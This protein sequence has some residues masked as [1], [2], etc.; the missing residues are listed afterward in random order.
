MQVSTDLQI[1][2]TNFPD[3]NFRNYLLSQ[4]YGSDAFLTTAEIAGITSINVS[5]KNISDLT[6]IGYFTALTDLYCNNNQ[7]QT[8]DVSSNTKLKI[9]D[10]SQNQL[11]TLNFSANTALINL[12]CYRNQLTALNVSA[13]T[14]LTDLYCNDNQL[15][16][17][18]FSSN[19]KLKILDCSRNQL[20]TL[21]VSANTALTNLKCYTNQLTA[22]DLTGL[23]LGTFDGSGQ[24]ATLTMTYNGA[25]GAF[26]GNIS[27]NNPTNLAAGISY[28]NGTL[29]STNYTITSTPFTVSTN[30]G[31]NTL[32]GTL[33]LNYPAM[34]KEPT[35]NAAIDYIN[36]T[37][38]GLSSGFF[39]I[40]NGNTVNITGDYPINAAWFNTTL[41]IIKTGNGTTT[42]DSDP[43][44]I[45]I[46]ARPDAPATLGHTFDGRIT[47]VTSAMEYSADG[48]TWTTCPDGEVAGLAA[49]TYQVRIKATAS[50]FHS[51]NAIITIDSGEGSEINPYIIRTPE[52][53]AM[54][55][56]L[57]NAD[58]SNYT[59]FTDK[60]YRLGN[61]IDLTAYLSS[62]GAGYNSGKGWIP[63]GTINPFKGVFDGGGFSI[64]G[65]TVNDNTLSN[66]GLFGVLDGATIKNLGVAGK[67]S[68]MTNNCGG[69]AGSIYNGS[70]IANCYSAANISGAGCV[71]GLVGYVFGGSIANCYSTGNVSGTN[72]EVG[73]I[74]G[75]IVNG[76]SIANCYAT[77]A[78]SSGM[79]QAGGIAGSTA[80]DCTI[81]NC[82]ALNPGVTVITNQVGRVVGSNSSTTLQNNIAFAG[83]TLTGF[84]IDGDNGADAFAIQI[85]TAT[86]LQNL[87]SANDPDN[88]WTY[89]DKYLPGLFG[90]TVD[91][92]AYLKVTG[93]EQAPAAPANFTATPDGNFAVRLDWTTPNNGGSAI[94]KYQ[95]SYNATAGYTPDWTD[96]PASDATTTS[97]TLTGLSFGTSYTFELRAVNA[98]G[99]GASSGVQTATPVTTDK[100]VMIPFQINVLKEGVA[101]YITC[102]V[103]TANIA[104]GATGNVTWTD[105]S[106]TA[107]SAPAGIT[108]SVS[109]VANNAATITF[110]GN[111]ATVAGTYFF[112]VT[113]DGES[114]GG[115]GMLF[116]SLPVTVSEQHGTLTAG[117]AGAV[118]FDVSTANIP[119]GSMGDVFWFSDAAGKYINSTTSLLRAANPF[120]DAPAGITASVDDLLNNRTTVAMTADNT[121]AAGTY[122]FRALIIYGADGFALSDVATLTISPSSYTGVPTPTPLAELKVYPNPTSG[123]LRIESG[124]L[125]I[126]K[127][128]IL[129]L[130]G[131]IILNC[132]FSPVNS[133]NVSELSAGIYF[134]RITMNG[135]TAVYKFVKK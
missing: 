44:S 125:R 134:L 73:G 135:E 100:T 72:F 48:T 133:I 103:L 68:G 61:N 33:A 97:Y 37:L 36:E 82:A 83:M 99:Y 5:N 30:N 50:A 80:S 26:N 21:N 84:F 93:S 58:N 16:A 109:A 120:G 101:G 63:I 10:C 56:T 81:K 88:V 27:L 22:L 78:V 123:E 1:N 35:P 127:A 45:A 2:A 25:A 105:M 12:T 17:L 104:D 46:L 102:D 4:P 60:N 108:A 115:G 75:S 32:S 38:T 90:N 51:E 85:N 77:G 8:L 112:M 91:M 95:V 13:N 69:I 62:T 128:E 49:G 14:A 41:T 43:Q 54:L 18:D 116:V 34:T 96:I 121:I 66:S 110:T 29:T 74:A 129:D 3:A 42:I 126:D 122:W 39:Y 6:G 79:E 114:D 24:T 20:T 70:S 98:I 65:L 47:G 113:I 23:N 87:F 57:I 31:S 89:V 107:C 59:N 15:T 9:L 7:L 111:N 11:T 124:E 92:P 106:G 55:A 86:F 53:L 131:K 132:Q 67:I 28:S 118:A 76:S 40:I 19:T 119:D 71:G 94:L 52:E 130:A 64:T 117:T